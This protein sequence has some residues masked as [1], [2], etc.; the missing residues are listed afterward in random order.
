LL[1]SFLGVNG[2]LDGTKGVFEKPGSVAIG[3][4]GNPG[5]LDNDVS[6]EVIELPS[7][8]DESRRANLYVLR[9]IGF[10]T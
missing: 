3:E 10:W 4:D 5:I 7:A 2:R 1:S 8:L 6:P 9:E